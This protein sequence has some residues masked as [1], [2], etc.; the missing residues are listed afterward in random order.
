MARGTVVGGII[1]ATLVLV[2]FVV[3]RRADERQSE[4]AA[5][6]APAEAAA[7]ADTRGDHLYGQVT[8]EDGVIHEGRLRFG[9]D[10]EAF[11][12]HYFN[13][14]KA[15]NRW[16]ALV[17]PERL[18]ERTPI[19]ILG[20]D[21]AGWPRKIALGRPFMARFGDI[22]RIEARGRTLRVTLRSGT[23]VEL[24]RFAADDFADGVRVWDGIRGTVDLD[25]WRI[26]TIDFMPDAQ[27]GP[28][29]GRLY[30]TVRTRHG[31]FT[32]FLQWNREASVASDRLDGRTAEGEVSLRFEAIRSI[33][34]SSAGRTVVT[35]LDGR[36]ILLADGPGV[37]DRN[38]GIYVDDPRY[39]RVLVS[40]D[41]FERLDLRPGGA[42]LAYGDFRPGRPL[43]GSVVT[44]S[45]R[46]LTGRLVYDLDES[47]STETLDA[48]REG[49][50]YTIPFSL[51]ATIRPRSEEGGAT[52]ARV[53][54]RS[55]EELVLERAGDLGEENGGM[56][57]FEAGSERPQYV[58]WAD[59]GQ[60]EIDPVPRA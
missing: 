47:E 26:R 1:T 54:L 40:W 56:L 5:S 18:K 45:G 42:G 4:A 59:V 3:L 2:G 11:W 48:P 6:T 31:E 25:E 41:A 22:A 15:D 28:D 9:G 21:I 33:A 57:I 27:P 32:G 55:G 51:V 29:P 17:P 60:I 20:V 43:T 53:L 14:V 39:G 58:P 23:V 24:D 44:R 7:R 8:M 10:E 30:G 37:G 46:R 13:G 49:V 50:D 36:E 38:R 12:D 34:R 52:H 16:A 35:L 19:E